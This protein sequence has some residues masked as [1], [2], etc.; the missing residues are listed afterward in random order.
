[1][2]EHKRCANGALRGPC[3]RRSSCVPCPRTSAARCWYAVARSHHTCKPPW[4]PPTVTGMF[5]ACPL[6]LGHIMTVPLSPRAR[7]QGILRLPYDG[8]DV[9]RVQHAA[10]LHAGYYQVIRQ[11][12]CAL[13]RVATGPR[14]NAGSFFAIA[15]HRLHN[16]GANDSC[17]VILLPYV[18]NSRCAALS[19][20]CSQRAFSSCRGPRPF[21]PAAVHKCSR[22]VLMRAM[23]EEGGEGRSQTVPGPMR[24]G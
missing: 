14:Q 16:Q 2:L 3:K 20:A 17:T 7:A 23:P 22:T 10:M 5:C 8:E 13:S 18:N 9:A 21:Q 6:G 24:V 12:D 11:A 19:A 4:D 1:M 15:G